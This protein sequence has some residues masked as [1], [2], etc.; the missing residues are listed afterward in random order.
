MSRILDAAMAERDQALMTLDMEYARRFMPGASSDFVRLAAMH[1]V[2]YE[3]TTMP[4]EL[5]HESGAWLREMGYGRQC[6][7]DL[8]PEGQLP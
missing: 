1:K 2:R 7:L 8:L 4:R 6:G 3:I 5:R